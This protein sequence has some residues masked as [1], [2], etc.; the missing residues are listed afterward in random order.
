[1]A[2]CVPTS[3]PWSYGAACVDRAAPGSSKSQRVAVDGL[4]NAPYGVY[5]SRRGN[6]LAAHQSAKTRLA[7]LPGELSL[8]QVE[9]PWARWR[10]YD[11]QLETQRSR[12]RRAAA[13]CAAD[14]G[15]LRAEAM[16]RYWCTYN[17]RK[18]YA[19]YSATG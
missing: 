10:G 16:R 5:R 1:M 17:W 11:D 18:T 12:A 14:A 2:M 8:E 19:L 15:G 6:L 3:C 9:A 13:A 4:G 7:T